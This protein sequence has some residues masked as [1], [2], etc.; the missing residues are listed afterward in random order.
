MPWTI[1]VHP[2]LCVCVYVC[3]HVCVLDNCLPP[4]WD[5]RRRCRRHL[6]EANDR[7]AGGAQRSYLLVDGARIHSGRHVL[8]ETE[9]VLGGL[10]VHRIV[11]VHRRQIAMDAVPVQA[12]G[13]LDRGR[14]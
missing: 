14:R 12:E 6:S 13:D 2:V 8:L 1:Y 5:R 3:V 7:V 11:E 10:A 9:L 4:L